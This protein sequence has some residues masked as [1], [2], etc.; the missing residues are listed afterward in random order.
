MKCE[1]S[2]MKYEV[3]W[4]EDDGTAAQTSIEASNPADAAMKAA[5]KHRLLGGTIVTVITT[6]VQ[7]R[8]QSKIVGV[9]LVR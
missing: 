1:V 3:T 8:I 6:P 2:W 5:D 9:D 7:Y 4:D